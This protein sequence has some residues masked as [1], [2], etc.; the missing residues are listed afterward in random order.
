MDEEI[1]PPV[2]TSFKESSKPLKPCSKTTRKNTN[3]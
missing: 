3:T 1:S 2:Q